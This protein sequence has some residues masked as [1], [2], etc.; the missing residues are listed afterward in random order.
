MMAVFEKSERLRHIGHL[1]IMR[2]MQRALRRSGLP[3]AYSNGFNPHILLTFA[4]A[5]SVGVV[6]KNEL[7]EAVLREDVTPE[8]FLEAMNHALPPDM[9]LRG[10]RVLDDR[11]TALMAAVQAAEYDIRIPDDAA[12]AQAC[13]D[14]VAGFLT[15]EEIMAERKTKSGV[16]EVNIRPLI[17]TL[18]A[19]GDTIHAVLALT[20]GQACKVDMLMGA[21]CAFA[22][23][24]A[25]RTLITRTHLM[26][27]AADGSFVPLET[28]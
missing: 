6:G 26:G 17:Y 8:H 15:Q 20:E 22:G 3:V 9:Q 13:V 2:A 5:L 18:E 4:S 25:P 19:S 16:K 11:A 21:L 7:M 10:A 14:A 24:E 23:I 1:D 27:Q 12:A 28:L